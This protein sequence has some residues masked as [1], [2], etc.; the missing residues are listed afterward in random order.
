M[1]KL[2]VLSYFYVIGFSILNI[3]CSYKSY[4]FAKIAVWVYTVGV[5]IIY[6][7]VINCDMKWKKKN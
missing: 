4:V 1:N 6:L 2:E 5:V 7:I 3:I